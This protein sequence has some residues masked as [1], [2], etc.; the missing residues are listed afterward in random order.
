MRRVP[1]A[2]VHIL[3]YGFLALLLCWVA[4]AQFRA[5]IQGTITDSSGAVVPGAKITLTNEETGVRQETQSELEGFYRFNSLPPG[6]YA[7]SVESAGFRKETRE[8]VSVRAERLEGVNLV[9]TPGQLN[10]SIVVSA[11][12]APR[13][14]TEDAS[15]DTTLTAQEV[16]SLPQ[17]GRDPFELVRLT[18]G[19]FGLGARSANGSS[20][21]LPNSSGPGGSN[22]SIYQ[23]EN[24]VPI[25][26]NGQRLSANG[27]QI[28]GVS[29]DSQAWGGAA[30][31][32]PNQ[33]SVKEV[34]VVSN[35]YSAENGRSSGALV[36][37]VSQNGTNDI[38]GS[39][40]MTFDRPE[41]NAYNK[42]GGPT[43]APPIKVLKSYNQYG[44][45]LGGPV[46]KDRTFVF[47]SFDVLPTSTANQSNQW[48]ETPELV[49]RIK[50]MRP[51]SIAAKTVSFP[52]ML[53]DVSSPSVLIPQ[54][55]ASV[56]LS[57]AQCKEVPGGLD[58][59][60]LTGATGANVTSAVGGG[61]DG[62]P[63]IRYGTLITPAHDFGSQYNGRVDSH[64][65]AK[66]LLAFSAYY[67]IHDNSSVANSRPALQWGSNRRMYSGALL[68]T[69]TL[70]PSSVNEARA[71]V[72]RWYFN[73][74]TDLPSL[75][76]G[77]PRQTVTGSPFPAFFLQ[78]GPSGGGVFYQTSYNVR[79][80][81]TTVK[82]KHVL[83]FG[84]EHFRE[85]NND[86]DA[87]NMR[88][89][90][91]F[92]N[93]WNFANDVP[94]TE[95]GNFDPLTGYPSDR[96]KYVR[97]QYWG[98]FVQDDWKVRPNLTVNLGLRWE[99]FGPITE[100][101]GK[102]SNPVLGSGPDPLTGI[103]MKVGG[104]PYSTS[105]KNFAPQ[106]GF[107]WS[108]GD[109]FGHSFRNKAVL[110]GGFG[111]AYNRVPESLTLNGRVNPPLP[112]SFT[113]TGNQ[114]LYTLATSDLAGPAAAYG[115]PR[116]PAATL[117][118]NP[119]TG[120]PLNGAKPNVFGI[121][122]QLVNP[123]TYR[124]SLELQYDLGG[125]W[126]P[127]LTYQGS[128]SHKL[129]RVVNYSLWFYPTNPRLA[130]VNYLRTDVNSNYNAM[131]ARLARSFSRGFSVTAQY[132]W[133][134]SIDT[135][136][137]DDNCRQSYP[138][139]QRTERGPSDFDVTH[140]FVGYALW[141]PS[142]LNGRKDWIGNA[143]GGWGLSGILTASSGF[144]WTAVYTGS[145]CATTLAG[146]GLCPLRPI[147]YLGGAGTDTS[148][149][150]FMKPGGNFPGGP[151]RY[152][153]PPT[154][155]GVAVPPV[156]GIGR[157]T[158]RGP[159]FFQLDMTAEKRFKIARARILGE[160]AQVNL[161]A[162]FFNILNKLNLSPFG[163]NSASTQITNVR[164]GQATGARSGRVVE[165]Q[166]RFS[167]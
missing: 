84:V 104:N 31:V 8:H 11:S 37:V 136:S 63:D 5:G 95:T 70:T 52:N 102:L 142:I 79:D 7:I 116:N 12:D 117:T 78:F 30:I 103:T 120:I 159:N 151:Y 126:V 45:S 162:N 106:F 134:K 27:Y 160:K 35:S 26:A 147:A 156:P 124:Y 91:D 154:G 139:D 18:P 46:I 109:V 66:D 133:S 115:F 132:R 50:A 71:N 48:M 130:T 83:K 144:P 14:K 4:S 131:I 105:L 57:A 3:Q 128:T 97:S 74:I 23:T 36:Q 61:L 15:I 44:G 167:F 21:A 135:C 77:I 16:H 60:S 100:K 98:L 137:N 82:S 118:F 19:I 55:C 108:P 87:S 43:G 90:Y 69:H 51:G 13:L 141:T 155:G 25:S 59:G 75:P 148:N 2:L 152:F 38:H 125:G 64:V 33:E 94:A 22:S 10:E 158:F 150:T 86:I 72:S 164:F 9:L 62:V 113:L 121:P 53:Q 54:T 81:L 99:Y 157:N 111:V 76:W 65:T 107:A 89:S 165:F 68:W 28:D 29:V 49:E 149:A 47:F 39:Y 6:P 42:W 123:Y 145:D 92:S 163:F 93:L 161:S 114:I 40:R 80:I 140:H 17:V 56:G 129:P 73:Q 34:R 143:F 32:T 166:L 153:V 20:E 110:R 58:I 85:Q 96:K 24:Q 41:L 67:T 119:D 127:S 112:T 101:Y 1:S 88:P 138:F 122:E 146:G